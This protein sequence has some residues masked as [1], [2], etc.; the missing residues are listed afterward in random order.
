MMDGIRYANDPSLCA[1]IEAKKKIW[2][3]TERAPKIR[4]MYVVSIGTS[5]VSKS[6]LYDKAKGWGLVSWALPVIDILQSSGAEV[7][8]YQ[9]GKLFEAEECKDQYIRLT[10]E[11]GDASDQMDDGSVKNI[12]AL[13]ESARTFIQSHSDELDKVIDDLINKDSDVC[14]V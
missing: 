11:I 10:P 14:P 6:Y 8:S 7:I 12:E 13:K 1:I 4:D 3:E 5:R 2:S 9:V